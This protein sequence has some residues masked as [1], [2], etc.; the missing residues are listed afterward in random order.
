MMRKNICYL[1]LIALLNTLKFIIKWPLLKGI[2]C[3]GGI[4]MEH[5][6]KVGSFGEWSMFCQ[7]SFSS[8]LWECS[9]FIAL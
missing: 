6:A 2:Y 9:R 3:T 5:R 1:R 7:N 4:E 8:F